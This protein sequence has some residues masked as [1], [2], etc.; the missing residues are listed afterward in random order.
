MMARN[1]HGSIALVAAAGRLKLQFP[2]KWFD[3]KQKY[4]AL[5]LTENPDNRLY[6][7]NLIR[8]IEWDYLKGELDPSFRKY[9]PQRK[10][11]PTNLGIGE[12]W[13]DYCRY[14]AK[15]LKPSTIH[16]LVNGLG[17]H[18]QRCPH[19]SVDRALEIRDWLLD[20]TTPDMSRRIVAVLASAVKWGIKHQ[21]VT[22]AINPF[23]EMS[24]DIRI[25]R[26]RSQPNAF[27]PQECELILA[28]FWDSEHY[29]HYATLVQ[30]WLW[31]G[32]RP[33]EGI[34]L[35]WEQ[36]CHDCS[37][38]VFDRSIVK[39]GNKIVKSHKSKTN[40]KRTFNC[41]PELQEFLLE[42]KQFRKP[43]IDL[44]FPSKAGKPIDYTNF[45]HRA[46]DKVAS[47]ILNRPSTPYNCRDTFITD[48]IGKGVPLAIIARW[49]DNSVD[50]I[51]KYYFD[52]TAI[53]NLTPR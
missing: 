33:S 23:T 10:P 15:N 17:R 27:T 53:D 34:G 39:V 38:I 48:Q 43:G 46:W 16:Y 21:K 41:Q 52:I 22:I 49:C 18:I 28:A 35:E 36:I 24:S 1:P 19:Q 47:P 42:L 5:G 7:S 29:D 2:R 50:I 4:L 8:E 14:K 3:G 13:A 20:T 32:C 44:V 40:R 30:F 51:E 25:D 12:L 9:F 26:E 31:T 45:S 37:K 6:A 11:L